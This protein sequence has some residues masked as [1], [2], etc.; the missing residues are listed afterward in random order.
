MKIYHYTPSLILW[1]VLFAENPLS[2]IQP[3]Q[4]LD[5]AL[6]AFG[7]DQEW[8]NMIFGDKLRQVLASASQAPEAVSARPLL[9]GHFVALGGKDRL[10][11]ALKLTAITIS[12]SPNSWQGA[13]AYMYRT[14]A[15]RFLDR[16]D[17]AHK[18]AIE[19]LARIDGHALIRDIDPDF[20][21][22]V[23][24][25]GMTP[26]TFP[27]ALRAILISIAM[28]KN[29]FNE[30]DEIAEKISDSL[31]REKNQ[32]RIR[33][34]KMELGLPATSSEATKAD[35]FDKTGRSAIESKSIQPAPVAQISNKNDHA[36]VRTKDSTWSR[37]WLL[38]G[39]TIIGAVLLLIWLRFQR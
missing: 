9:A 28:S 7:D 19:A 27:D 2:A 15:L 3:R 29:N 36:L 34:K 14:S 31:Q 12:E 11:E 24:P 4:L 30:A 8:G 35:K 25:R 13:V 18:A 21:K 37:H 20:R 32:R 23:G 6:V 1:L 17:D 22:V 39:S 38:I 16:Q 5:E 26:T 33:W 10:E